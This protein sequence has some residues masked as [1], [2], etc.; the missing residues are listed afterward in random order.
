MSDT[1]AE[2]RNTSDEDEFLEIT[3][4]VKRDDCLWDHGARSEKSATREAKTQAELATVKF[5]KV[6]KVKKAS[7]ACRPTAPVRKK[8]DT[9]AKAR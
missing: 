7:I 3:K 9:W 1:G 8:C 6:Q 4:F 5:Q 2:G